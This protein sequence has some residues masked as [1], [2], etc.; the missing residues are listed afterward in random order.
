VAPYSGIFKSSSAS[1]CPFRRLLRLN[2]VNSVNLAS[3]KVCTSRSLLVL[4]KINFTIVFFFFGGGGVPFATQGDK[5]KSLQDMIRKDNTAQQNSVTQHKTKQ[6][7]QH[8]T[9]NSK[10]QNSTAQRK[11][12]RLCKKKKPSKQTIR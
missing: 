9:Q 6:N 1:L 2:E 5:K 7:K 4:R 12:G 8:N 10:A 3:P 11:A